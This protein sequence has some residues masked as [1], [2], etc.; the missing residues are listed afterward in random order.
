MHRYWQ[1]YRPD[2]QKLLADGAVKAGAKIEYGS[3][4]RDVDVENGS[5]TL[6]DGLT[7]TADLVVCAD[8]KDLLYAPFDAC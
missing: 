5:L 2:F 7:I 3:A 4:V 1:I 6:G 8:G